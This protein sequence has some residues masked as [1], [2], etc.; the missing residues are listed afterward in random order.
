MRII[1]QASA[2]LAL[3]IG[4]LAPLGAHARED[5]TYTFTARRVLPVTGET[6]LE[7]SNRSGEI[8]VVPSADGRVSVSI[9][10]RITTRSR[11]EAMRIE[12]LT[13]VETGAAGGV[14]SVHVK[15]PRITRRFGIFRIDALGLNEEVV[16]SIAAPPAMKLALNATSGEV[17]VRGMRGPVDL[18]MTSGDAQMVNLGGPLD[19]RITSGNLEVRGAV[20][21]V[22]IVGTSCDLRLSGV[23]KNA[24]VHTSSGDITGRGLSTVSVRTVSGTTR[25][26]DVSTLDIQSTSGDVSVIGA[27]GRARVK[28]ISGEC[29]LDLDPRP[30]D[31]VDVGSTSGDLTV[32]FPDSAALDVGIS[33]TS[34]NITSRLPMS[35]RTASRRELQGRVGRGGVAVSLST[36]SGNVTL[37]RSA[38]TIP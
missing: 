27:H 17:V 9:E 21:P 2:A 36:I 10:K 22:E 31:T 13:V 30:G 25:L 33:T 16:L 38:E 23:T 4:L 12:R 14:I 20:G 19:C 1:A 29:D 7:V 3:A 26:R 8:T 5:V 15:Y 11:Q 37:D 24:I 34:G 18:D 28:T 35:V 6:T 32:R